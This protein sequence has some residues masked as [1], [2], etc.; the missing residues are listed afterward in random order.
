MMSSSISSLGIGSGV[1]TSDVIDQLREADDA[2]IITPLDNKLELQDKKDEAFKLLDTLL[3]SFKSSVSSLSLG[4]VYQNRTVDITGGDL[5]V[6]AEAGSDIEAFSLETTKLAQQNIKQSAAFTSRTESVA[7]SDGTMHLSIGT[8]DPVTFDIAYTSGATLEELAEAINEEAGSKVTASIIQTGDEE[9]SLILRSDET[10]AE[11][12][13]SISDTP[14]SGA[15]LVDAISDTASYTDVLEAQDAEFIYNGIEI[16]R[17]SNSISDL[18][19]GV[20]L[21]LKTEGEIANVDIKQDQT[22]ITTEMSLLVESYN[23]LITNI[24]DMTLSDQETGA[25]GV[26]NGEGF[27]RTVSREI[28]TIMT[29][30]NGDNDSLVNYGI[31]IDRDGVM[32]FDASVLESKIN[33]DSDAVELFFTGGFDSESELTK[34]GVFETLNDKLNEFTKFNG[35]I[36]GFETNMERQRESLTE[37]RTRQI[38]LLDTRY[39]IMAKQFVAY[40]AIISKLTSQ[41]ASLELQIQAD[42]S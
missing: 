35:L 36:D 4:A 39:E 15:G 24:H 18:I 28:N 27:I 14:D 32:S 40:D 17:S 38:D 20:T 5:E 11:Q 2:R 10:G 16:T 33:T 6:T 41:F 3:T 23:T 8:T 19:N 42:S 34:T 37:Q 22:A 1:L 25:T 9:Y 7:D 12:N 30:V 26:F 21:N 29:S 13:I 31:D